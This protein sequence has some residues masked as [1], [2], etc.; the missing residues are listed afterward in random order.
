MEYKMREI[1]R[2]AR[3]KQPRDSART[4]ELEKKCVKLECD[5]RKYRHHAEE[6]SRDYDRLKR[7]Y[8]KLKVYYYKTKENS[9]L[10]ANTAEASCRS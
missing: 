1:E 8:E 10:S 6:R 3:T 4:A 9:A 7:E 2:S 5:A